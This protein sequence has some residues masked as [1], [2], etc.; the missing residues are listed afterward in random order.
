[1]NYTTAVFLIN[2]NVRAIRAI[3]EADEG[4]KKAPRETFK[5]LDQD[6]VVGDFVIVESGTRH[7]MTLVKVVEVDVDVDFDSV[8]PM[9]WVVD[10]VDATGHAGVL[11]KEEQA[12]QAIKSA[13]LRKKRDDLRAALI[14]DQEALTALPLAAI[15]NAEPPTE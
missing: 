13:E 3:Y 5:T 1:M 11:A 10:V 7:N 4:G 8:L 12:I 6:I 15:G 9:K 14:L 2:K